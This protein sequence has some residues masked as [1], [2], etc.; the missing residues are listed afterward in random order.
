MV[1]ICQTPQTFFI[2]EYVDGE[3]SSISCKGSMTFKGIR[4]GITDY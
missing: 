2:C 4:K 1:K 3:V